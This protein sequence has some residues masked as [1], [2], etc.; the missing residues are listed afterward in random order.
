MVPK[1]WS[2]Q[3]LL[4][5]TEY[6][7]ATNSSLLSIEAFARAAIDLYAFLQAGS[8]TVLEDEPEEAEALLGK[9]YGL[10]DI[11]GD[12]TSFL[13]VTGLQPGTCVPASFEL[14]PPGRGSFLRD[15][16]FT[17]RLDVGSAQVSG[18]PRPEPEIFPSITDR[19][20]DV[21]LTL[22]LS[23]DLLSLS[24][25]SVRSGSRIG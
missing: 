13:K 20:F 7:K 11:N 25:V 6:N 19:T 3:W 21:D 17:A 23:R 14:S 4:T 5:C 2:G 22:S 15:S 8:V 24:E 18:T 16:R 10:A 1:A 12:F 9:V